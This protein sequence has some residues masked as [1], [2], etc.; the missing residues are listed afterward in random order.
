M[1]MH[2]LRNT[3][4]RTL[5]RMNSLETGGSLVFLPDF[6]GNV[7]YAQPIQKVLSTEFSCFGARLAP[8]MVADLDNLSLIEIAERFATDIHQSDIPRPIHICGF[9]FAGLLAFETA[10]HLSTIEPETGELLILDTSIRSRALI[11]RFLRNPLQEILYIARYA[12]RNW[13]TLLPGGRDP[14]V[15][16][17]YGQIRMELENHAEAHRSIIQQLYA[18]MAEYQPRPWNGSVTVFRAEETPLGQRLDDLGWAHLISGVLTLVNVPG[19]HLSM[20]RN[21]D[22]AVVLVE[23]MRLRLETV[24]KE[25]VDV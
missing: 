24:K 17:R 16:H 14:L 20:L 8:D 22:N 2:T 7:I 3:L 23:K 1:N 21:P 15:L 12:A 19:D 10:R 9:S 11:A 5:M 6:G 18:K 13:R 25:L 4:P